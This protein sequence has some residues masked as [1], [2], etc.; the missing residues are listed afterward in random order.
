MKWIGAILLLAGCIGCGAMAVRNLSGRVITLRSLT[1]ALDILGEELNF[2]L[3]PMVQWLQNTA[4][5]AAHPASAFL[6]ACANELCKGDER[7]L[8]DIWRSTARETLPQ[9]KP[10]DLE[11]VMEI[12]AVLGRYDADGQS[13]AIAAARHRLAAQLEVAEEERGR[14]GKVCGALSAAAGLFLVILLI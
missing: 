5:R 14:N 7:K 8:A 10:C 2:G 1:G 9:L 13:R 4:K 11:M 12:G 3:P 6:F